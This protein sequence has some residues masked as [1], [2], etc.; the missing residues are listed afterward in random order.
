MSRKK[1][2]AAT[3]LA[4]VL[5]TWARVVL[6]DHLRDQGYFLKYVELARSLPRERLVEVSPAYLWLMVLLRGVSLHA[7]RTMQIIAVSV[8]ALFAAMA[9]HRLAGPLAGAVAAVLLL[10]SRATLVCATD[11]EPE[12]L[13]V[14][15]DAVALAAM[16]RG[17]WFGAGIALGL[18]A[19]ARPVALL[20]AAAAGVWIVRRDLRAAAAFAAAV[21]LPVV[22]AVSV[23]FALTGEAILMDPGGVLYEGMNPSAT[24]YGGVQPAIVKDIEAASGQP[25][26]LHVASRIVASRALG[27]EASHRQSNGWWAAK[28]IAFARTYPSTAAR[29]VARKLLF[30][31]HSYDSWDLVTMA[32][33]D[34]ALQLLPLWVPLG[35][36]VPLAGLALL[37]RRRAA[38]LPLLFAGGSAI[39]LIAAYASARQRQALM[40]ALAVAAAIGIAEIASMWRERRNEAAGAAAV[41]LLIAV[42]LSVNGPAQREDSYGWDSSGDDDQHAFDLALSLERGGNWTGADAILEQ[43]QRDGYQ[44]RRESRAVSSVAFYRARAALHLRGDPHPQLAIAAREAPG[45][46]HLLGLQAVL[47]DRAALPIAYALH[48]PFSVERALAEGW[49]DLGRQANARMLLNDLARRIPEWRLSAAPPPPPPSRTGTPAPPRIPAREGTPAAPPSPLP[50]P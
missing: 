35:A 29:L 50:R 39:V 3:F 4:L 21:A 2:L 20:A 47:G 23:N 26:Y 13:I 38:A 22:L 5:V 42:L 25:D 30:A 44:P 31:V 7:I 49:L 6:V 11:L 12:A 27:V 16:V 14:L 46:V 45:D 28:S 34:R 41:I 32:R 48:D 43:L 24:G 36:L 8:A 40:P 19:T 37:R 17:R 18:S 10:A 1:A 15:L 9:A 33:K